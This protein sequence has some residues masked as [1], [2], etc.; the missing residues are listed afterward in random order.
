MKIENKPHLVLTLAEQTIL[1]KCHNLL[2][3]MSRDSMTNSIIN[4]EIMP[5]GFSVEDLRDGIGFI[6]DNVVIE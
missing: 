2:C 3:D 4:S 6:I 5:C 1:I